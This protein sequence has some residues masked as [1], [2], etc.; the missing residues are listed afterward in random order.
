MT[1]S[2]SKDRG[3]G[4]TPGNKHQVGAVRELAGNVIGGL[5]LWRQPGYVSR[6]YWPHV[7]DDDHGQ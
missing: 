7:E 1:Q 6:A 4:R 5:A 3:G 2:A